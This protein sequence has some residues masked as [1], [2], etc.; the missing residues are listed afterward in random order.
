[1]LKNISDRKPN[2]MIE[3]NPVKQVHESKSLGVTID[4]HLSWNKNTE[5]IW[6]K[7]A[8]GISVLR[9][10]K[11]VPK[12]TLLSIFNSLVHPYF[13]YCSEVWDVLRETQSKRLQNFRIEQLELL[14]I[15]K[16]MSIMRSL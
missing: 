16:M 8:S 5:N 15:W 12:E 11:D 6:K 14:R 4:Q 13:T 3:N 7:L 1:M 9:Q 2:I 10:A